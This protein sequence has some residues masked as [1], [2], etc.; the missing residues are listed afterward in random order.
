MQSRPLV[1]WMG[2]GWATDLYVRTG[3]RG[4][5]S[6]LCPKRVSVVWT[7]RDRFSCV[8]HLH[9]FASYCK[10][11][12]TSVTTGHI[13][14]PHARDYC[15]K[16]IFKYFYWIKK[17]VTFLMQILFH[18]LKIIIYAI[19]FCIL[20]ICKYSSKK[21]VCMLYSVHECIIILF[22]TLEMWVSD[23]KQLSYDE[24]YGQSSQTNCTVYCGG[25]NNGLT[26]KSISACIFLFFFFLA[27][28]IGKILPEL[29]L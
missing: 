17:C 2:S 26:G 23:V 12:S 14:A 8:W 22:F 13:F 25:V 4:N 28:P 27:L 1:T 19:H 6:R 16:K 3:P 18:V 21:C 24:V 5:L 9:V 20:H 29:V 7:C 11:Q 15:S 10:V